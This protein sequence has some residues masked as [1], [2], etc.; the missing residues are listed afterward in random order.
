MNYHYPAQLGFRPRV[1]SRFL[2]QLDNQKV[3]PLSGDRKLWLSVGKRLLVF[4]PL[5][6]AVNLWLASSFK[7]LEQ[8]VHMLE[9]V[10]HQLMEQHISLKAK[11][12][13]LF[14][15]ER[16]R[17]IAAE[18]LSLYAPEKEQVNFF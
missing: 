2:Q 7:D 10:R 5:L 6:L 16:V 18:K 17:I 13:Q 14:S 9:N 1:N 15:P 11:R 8:S 12:D 4:C 3:T